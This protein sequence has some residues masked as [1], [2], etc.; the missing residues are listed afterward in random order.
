MQPRVRRSWA[1][2]TASSPIPRSASLVL[3]SEGRRWPSAARRRRAHRPQDPPATLSP[4]ARPRVAAVRLKLEWVAPILGIDPGGIDDQI[5]DLSCCQVESRRIA[6][7]MRLWR[8]RSALDAIP[9]LTRTILDARVSRLT[10]PRAATAA[11]ELVPPK[12]GP[13]A[14]PAGRRCAR[15]LDAPLAPAGSRLRG[16]LS[17]NLRPRPPA[18][19]R[20]AARRPQS[21][22]RL[23]GVAAES[24]YCDQSHLIRDCLA[25]G[26]AAPQRLH[27][28]RVRQRVDVAERSNRA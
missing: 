14:L 11:L 4:C 20:D 16:P 12:L 8:T 13:R 26:G 3:G 7:R 5:V 9:I 24:G 27:A 1:G 28:E 22:P 23:A 6:S 2:R 17:E 19:T 10:P 21:T 25:L 18:R 15:R